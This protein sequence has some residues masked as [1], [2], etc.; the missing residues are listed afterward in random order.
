MAGALAAGEARSTQGPP[1]AEPPITDWLLRPFAARRPFL[2]GLGYAGIFFAAG[3]AFRLGSGQLARAFWSDPYFWLDVLNASVFGYV[4]AVLILLRR[5]RLRDLQDLRP[6]LRCDDAEFARLEAETVCVRPRVLALSGLAGALL[7]AA[8]PILDPRF[9]PEGRP[10]SLLDP[11]M[12]FLALR[13]AATG[14]L[15]GHVAATEVRGVRAFLRIGRSRVTADPLDLAPLAPFARAGQ[16]TAL[17]WVLASSLVSLFWLGPGAGTANAWIVASILCAVSVGFFYTIYG[18][19]QNL[20][21]AKREALE[22]LNN[23]IRAAS[24]DLLAGRSSPQ[25]ASVADLVALHGFV[26]GLREWPLGAPAVVRGG[27]IG[28]LALGSWL[29]GALVERVLERLI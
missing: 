9:W 7:F 14:W 24:A 3:L 27:L 22:A 17:A 23:R 16:R 6:L 18:V 2:T 29:G 4:P 8:M 15:V 10:A 20:Q 11:D 1:P 5:G 12:V 21:A 28:A 19:H 25:G 13:M 26:A